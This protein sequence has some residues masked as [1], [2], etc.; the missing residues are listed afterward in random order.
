MEGHTRCC[1]RTQRIDPEESDAPA[2]AEEVT[3]HAERHG[4]ERAE[5]GV[6]LSSRRAMEKRTGK[7]L[8]IP[9]GRA[10]RFSGMDY[11]G[12]PRPP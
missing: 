3:P 9:A 7:P 8:P 11:A 5:T 2:E 4:A 6:R 1:H 10:A 12:C